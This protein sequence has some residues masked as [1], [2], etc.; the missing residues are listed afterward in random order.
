MEIK[1]DLPLIVEQKRFLEDLIEGNI[2]KV[3][4][5][6]QKTDEERYRIAREYL[7]PPYSPLTKEEEEFYGERDFIT[8][9]DVTNLQLAWY[10]IDQPKELRDR[11]SYLCLRGLREGIFQTAEIFRIT[12]PREVANFGGADIDEKHYDA[13]EKKMKKTYEKLGDSRFVK[14]IDLIKESIK[15]RLEQDLS[16]RKQLAENNHTFLE[17]YSGNIAYSVSAGYGRYILT[18]KL[19]ESGVI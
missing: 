17:Y 3:R 10:L 5:L 15:K 11:V 6:A 13:K 18:K 12:D 14:R 7:P 1:E 8:Y 19:Q 9:L 16:V 2:P 4:D